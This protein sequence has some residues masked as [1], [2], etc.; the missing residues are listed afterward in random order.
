MRRAEMFWEGFW[1]AFTMAG[2]ADRPAR[3]QRPVYHAALVLDS[4]F[5]LIGL[6]A[7]IGFLAISGYHAGAAMLLAGT[8]FVAAAYTLRPGGAL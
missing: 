7:V 2:L 3:S 8:A 4:A 1:D 6:I 5:E